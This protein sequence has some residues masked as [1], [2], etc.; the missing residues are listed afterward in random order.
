MTAPSTRPPRPPATASRPVPAGPTPLPPEPPPSTRRASTSIRPS[1]TAAPPAPPSPTAASAP[2]IP[3]RLPRDPAAGCAPVY[4]WNFVR[5]NT[6]FGV[7]HN[8]G[9]YTAW[10]DKH[11]AYSS[12]AGPGG[13]TLDDFY[14]PEINSNVV[15]LPGV[16]TPEGLSCANVP[17][18]SQV[19]SWTDSF[20]N[21]KCYD[22]LKVNAILNQID[23][24]THNGAARQVP[25]IF[26]MNF[27]AVSVGQKLIEKNVGT[28]GYTDGAGT[29]TPELLGEIQFIDAAIGEMV[30][31][32]KDSGNFENTLVIITAK[33][34]QAPIDPHR[35]T[36]IPGHDR[37]R[38]HNARRPARQPPPNLGITQPAPASAPP[39]TTSPCSGSPTPP[40]PK[41]P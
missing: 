19:G 35:F 6:I 27:Q 40:T 37:H 26:G 41:P 21:I 17:D 2:S 9:G 32:L 11:P 28:G 12:V 38:R 20:Q 33:H 10:S 24:K 31:A 14:A 18:P 39:R 34:G 7:I 5:T 36:P 3:A 22:T 1:S 29:P 8:A 30:T 25:S 13:N 15:P 4:P 16:S 23:G